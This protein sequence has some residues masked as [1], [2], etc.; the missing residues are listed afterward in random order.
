M[1]NKASKTRLLVNGELY[2]EDQAACIS[3]QDRGLQFG[4][5]VFE[6]I[7]CRKNQL[8]FWDYHYERM[9][10]GCEK[11]QMECPSET[12]L[13]GDI[14]KIL[15]SD[16]DSVVKIIVSRGISARGYRPDPDA[17]VSRIC[18]VSPLMSVSGQPLDV[19]MCHHRLPDE[20]ETGGIKHCNRLDQVMARLEWDS[21][22]ADEGL[23]CNFS[24]DIISGT[25]SNIFIIYDQKLITPDLAGSAGVAGTVR[26]AA[27]EAARELGIEILVSK[28]KQKDIQTAQ[29][30][31]LTN[32]LMLIAPVKTLQN[33]SFAIPGRLTKTLS[34][35]INKE[36]EA[37][38]NCLIL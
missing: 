24:G 30:V 37:G 33:K 17:S 11:L 22:G 25:M 32:S 1:N 23:L 16:E 6:T 35:Y 3:P 15:H 18:F 26:R 4:D 27:I 9:Q 31:F 19:V 2:N 8:E 20:S 28:V 7:A 5:G 29:E 34:D 21:S 12:R 13:L 36:I 38:N 10:Q 14:T